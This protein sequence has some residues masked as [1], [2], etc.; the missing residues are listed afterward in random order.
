MN[1]KSKHVF[2]LTIGYD[3]GFELKYFKTLVMISSSKPMLQLNIGYGFESKS[4]VSLM[5]GWK[6]EKRKNL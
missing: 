3:Y 4:Q 2:R 5:S 1:S 6:E